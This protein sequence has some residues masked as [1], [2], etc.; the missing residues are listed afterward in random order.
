MQNFTNLEAVDVMAMINMMIMP[1]QTEIDDLKIRVLNLET[2]DPG[3]T[4]PSGKEMDLSIPPGWKVAVREDFEVDCAEGE[5]GTKYGIRNIGFYPGPGEMS[6]AAYGNASGGTTGYLDTSKR[7]KY[8]GKFISVSGSVLKQRGFVDAS[9]NIWVSAVCPFAKPGGTAKWGDVPA[10]I[11]EQRT[12]F[13]IMDPG[14]KMAHLAWPVSNTNNPDG[15]IDWPEAEK[16]LVKGYIHRQNPN[17][18]GVQTVITPNP[19]IDMTQ[20]HTYRTEFSKGQ[21]VR[22]YC[23]GVLQGQE[24]NPSWVPALNM[25][26]VLQN[27]T[28][29]LRDSNNVLI[30]IPAASKYEVHTDWM[31]L[32]T[33]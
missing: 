22:L 10:F 8:T 30:P 6:A 13:P 33:P 24:T 3:S 2:P 4:S 19:A 25:H 26:L 31:Q 5:F 27:E 1:M 32:F 18:N 15:E 11:F 20:W 16:K 12:R 21:Y 14:F 9:G 28:S 23:D 7:G 29:L 17:T